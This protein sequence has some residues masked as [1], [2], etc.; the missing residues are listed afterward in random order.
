M[1]QRT[2]PDIIYGYMK[3]KI[4]TGVELRTLRLG[5]HFEV[6]GL[7]ECFRKL[8]LTNLTDSCATVSGESALDDYSTNEENGKIVKIRNWK[9]LG[10]G[11]TMSTRTLVKV[12]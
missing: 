2:S 4:G 3:K 11:H 6:V 1:T 8:K 5:T 10:L 9:S 7:E 12:L